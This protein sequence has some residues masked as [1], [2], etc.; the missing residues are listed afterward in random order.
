MCLCAAAMD[1]ALRATP[2]GMCEGCDGR[3]RAGCVGAWCVRALMGW[4]VDRGVRGCVWDSVS[5]A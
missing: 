5:Q 4:G 2:K 3:G 1:W